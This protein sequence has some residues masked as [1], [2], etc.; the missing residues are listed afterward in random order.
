MECG[1]GNVLD[2]IRDG[3]VLKITNQATGSKRLQ[4]V[5][6]KTF[7]M[8]KLGAFLEDDNIFFLPKSNQDII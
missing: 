2:L 1:Q 8:Q 7:L 6:T 3:K 5:G 4:K